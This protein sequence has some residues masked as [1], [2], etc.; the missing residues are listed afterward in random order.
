MQAV[1][2]GRTTIE[3]CLHCHGLWFD[4]NDLDQARRCAAPHDIDPGNPFDGFDTNAQ[5][6]IRCPRCAQALIKLAFPA[7]THIDYEQCPHC[8]GA[9]LDAGEFTDLARR[10]RPQRLRQW[11]RRVRG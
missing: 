7:Q 5:R 4:R 3:R 6:N 8:G 2:F 9:F 1:H 11:W 10:Q